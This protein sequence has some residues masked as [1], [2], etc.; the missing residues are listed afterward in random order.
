MSWASITPTSYSIPQENT[1]TN[2]VFGIS[3]IQSDFNITAAW[4]DTNMEDNSILYDCYEKSIK[5]K[6]KLIISNKENS[7]GF[8]L[9]LSASM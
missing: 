3:S 9:F 2:K 6:S 5:K 7:F 4:R 1:S 8:N